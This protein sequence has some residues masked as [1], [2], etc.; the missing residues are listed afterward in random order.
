M[1]DYRQCVADRKFQQEVEADANTA[2]SLG[3]SGTPAFFVNGIP[4]TGALPLDQFVSVIDGE[5]ARLTP[6]AAPAS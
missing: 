3:L 2:Q 6:A 5:L 4:L 1:D